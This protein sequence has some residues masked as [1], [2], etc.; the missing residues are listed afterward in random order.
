MIPE[1]YRIKMVEPIRCISRTEREAVIRKADYNVFQIPANDVFIDLLTDSGTGA[2]SSAQWAAMLT[3]DEWYAGASSFFLLRDA[4]KDIFGF[5]LMMPAH[6]GRGAERVF[7]TTLLRKGNI[8]PSNAHFDTTRANIEYIGAQAIDL[9]SETTNDPSREAP[10]KGDMDC[11]KLKDILERHG[12]EIPFVMMTVTNNR[13]AGQPVSMDNLKRV[14]EISHRFHKPLYIDACRHAENAYFIKT[15]DPKYKDASI[16]SITLE[17][18][19]H[20]DGMLMSAKKDGLANIGGLIALRDES[21]FERLK[22]HLILTE[23]FSTYG[24]LAGRDLAAIAV[25]LR[26]AIDLEYLAHR[27]GQTEFLG[28]EMLARGVPVY[29]PFGGHAVYVN[30]EEFF[31]KRKLKL[32]GQCLVVALYIEGGIRTCD[33]GSGMFDPEEAAK[34]EGLQLELVRLAIPRRTYTEGHLRYV[35]DIAGR[36]HEQAERLPEVRMVFKPQYLGHF[37]ARF[38]LCAES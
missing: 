11:E 12:A 29:T 13:A 23:G 18:F 26:E 24:G 1:P 38:E 15:R 32:P 33:L 27:V 2:M 35:A 37:T 25:G 7:F 34:L 9:P 8:I 30:S 31:G 10:F 17:F 36:L 16:A 5:P 14:S 6:Q 20:S 3:G 19:S 21:V 4:V 28:R 22:T